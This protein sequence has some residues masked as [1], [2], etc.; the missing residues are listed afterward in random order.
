MSTIRT[1]RVPMALAVAATMACS[2]PLALAQ[3]GTEGA[4][5]D[6]VVHHAPGGIDYLSGGAGEESR[7][8]MAAHAREL[9]F[10]LVLSSAS[11]EYVVAEELVVRSPQAEA[12]TVRDA[13]PIV[14]MRLPP[15][16]YTLE[17]TVQ[18][19]TERRNVRVGS[20]AQTVD[21]RWPG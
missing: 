7:S 8:A 17:A 19:R 20:G 13:G 18:G 2:A 6:P 12:L 5:P 1:R 3:T 10:K 4:P 21:W 15:G 16:N 14:M 11:G 9:P